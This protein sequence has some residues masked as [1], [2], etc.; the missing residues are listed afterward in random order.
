MIK[1]EIIKKDEK[2]KA[3]AGVLETSHGIVETPVF[4]P[5]GTQATV[6]TISPAELKEIGA[7]A[8][9]ANAYH[10]YLRP[11]L[12]VIKQ[13]GGLHKFM[14][15]DRAIITDSGGY[16]IFSMASLRKIRDDGVEFQG[17]FD[18]SL[19]F[20]T[21]EKVIEIQN[22]LGA[23][24]IMA[25]DECVSYPCPYV[26]AEEAAKRTYIWAKQ[27]KSAHKNN[28]QVLFGITQGSMYKDLREKSTKELIDLNF[29]GYAIGGLSVGE[30]KETMLEI[31]DFSTKLLPGEKPRYLMGVGTPEDIFDC[32]ER[33]IDMFDCTMPTRNARNGTVFTSIGKIVVRNAEYSKDFTPLDPN[34][35][36]YTCK[37]FSR[38][39]IRHLLNV[40]EI[41]GMRLTSFHNLAFMMNLVSYIRKSILEGTFVSLK[42]EFL[43]KTSQRCYNRGVCKL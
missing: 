37:N 28:N 23:D 31:V 18:G 33:G 20:F 14:S 13:A 19:H 4:M 21:P 1:F 11:G 2:T 26:H 5:V 43:Q 15:W 29:S 41:L 8:I 17:H 30:P 36:C 6:K 22:I 39:Y 38:A 9:L 32:V 27:C 12:D 35:N 16:Q 40:G 42:K 7:N 24:I 34:C 10:L 25:F 3:R